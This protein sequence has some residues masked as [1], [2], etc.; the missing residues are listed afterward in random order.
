[1]M[2]KAS[3]IG[4]PAPV[5]AAVWQGIME[6]KL[7]PQILFII[8]ALSFKA[9]KAACSTETD[10]Q[11]LLDF[12][13]SVSLDPHE[14][15]ASWNDTVHFCKWE[16]VS[17]HN[18]KHPLRVT[19]MNLAN[20]GLHGHISPS[21]GNLTLLTALNL[22]SLKFLILGN[23]SL[24][25]RIP[26]ELTN[27]TS[28]R[29]VDLSWNQLVGEIPF[30][31]AS[32]SELTSLDL[33]RNNLTGGIPS[34]ISNISNL[35][36]LIAKE[37]QLEGRIPH[38]LGHLHL[39]TFLALGRNKLSGPIPQSIF[40]LSSLEI[41]SLESNYLSMPYLPSDLGNTLHNL[42][43]LYLDY[44]NFRGSI[45]PS[46]SNATHLVDLDLSSNS[47]AGHVPTTLGTLRKP[48]WLN[49][50]YNNI[51]AK[52]KQS[53]MFIDALANCSSLNVLA[54]FQN[55]LKGE[56]PSSV[57]NLSSQLQYLLL[58]QNEL[59]GHVPS[60][61]GNLQGLTSLGLDSN[62][63]DGTILDISDNHLNGSMPVD[64]FGLP[65]LISFNLSYNYF[66][67]ILPLEVGNANE[68]MEEE[69]PSS[70]RNLKS[71]KTL[72]I[73]RNNLSGPIPGFLANLQ[74]LQQLDLSYNNLQGEIP[75][76]GVFR[77]ATALTLDGNRNLCGGVPE[78]SYVDLAKATD[79]FSPSNLIGK[80]AH[81]SVYKGFI[82]HLNEIVAVKVFNLETKGAQ[83][84]FVVEC[85]ALRSVR[86]R[87]PVS[88]LTACSS[89][90]SMGNEFKAIVYEFMHSGNLDMFLHSQEYKEHFPDPAHL[91]LTHRVNIAIDV[92]NALNYLHNSLQPPIVHC[93][94]KPNNILLD[95][96]MDAHVGDFGLARLHNDGTSSSIGGSTSSIGLKGTTGYVAPEYAIG[97]HISTAGDVYSFGIL[98]L[99]MITGKRPT[100][101]MFMEGMSIVTF[102]QKNFPDQIMQIIDVNLQYD[103]NALHKITKARKHECL[104]SMLDMGLVCTQQCPKERPDMRE[105]ARKLHRTR[106]AYLE[107][108]DYCLS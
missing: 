58:G 92:A 23:N 89:I 25:G 44:N 35:R 34:S 107:D 47:F 59:A 37:N 108:V 78:V 46:L 54:L 93:D 28:L 103:D 77:N 40:N 6:M 48:S 66:H 99:E 80:G 20:K 82:G 8:S 73:S 1:M 75:R 39:L 84:S 16:G 57:G 18:A 72:N 63:F 52:D 106:V 83:N 87:N 15:L 102:V 70:L 45:P 96:D 71:L 61:I 29:I 60:S 91:S 95:D 53:W 22:R 38:E 62:N 101:K 56:L 98:L 5:K 51:I 90:D 27:Y 50:E 13:N 94:L 43:R 7:L 26:N 3:T 36:E 2:V 32:L 105:V 55:Q 42:Q 64:L 100:D 21:L 74:S 9:S 81:G 76:N 30:E 24:Q 19:A 11:S 49:L 17:C 85:Q 79:N 14:A 12:K 97:G 65:S 88:V 104:L 4:R 86:H 31:V 10:R 33:S 69:I 67:G 68:L 41:V